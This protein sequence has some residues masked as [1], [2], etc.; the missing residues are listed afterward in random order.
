MN[1]QEFEGY[2]VDL[3]GERLESE[4]LRASLLQHAGQC[5]RC[6]SLIAAHRNLASGLRALAGAMVAE[7]ASDRVEQA[8][9]QQL[10]KRVNPM[11]TTAKASSA[12]APWQVL[13]LGPVS[14][15]PFCY[16]RVWPWCNW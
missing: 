6:A 1:C 12:K 11:P 14:R 9:R 10:R 5:S 8:L 4:S 15:L 2:L 3:A 16:W 13:R 7:K